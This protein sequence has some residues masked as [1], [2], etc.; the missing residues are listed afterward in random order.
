M[1][2]A[3]LVRSIVDHVPPLLGSKS[4]PEVANNY[5]GASSFK[6]SMQNLDRSLRNIADAYLHVQIRSKESVPT[7]V[8]VNFC[9]D[10]DVLLAEII[11]LVSMKS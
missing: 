3:M 11:R 6:K 1:S 8:Q 7:P 4:F 2:V 10:L 5:R 9:A